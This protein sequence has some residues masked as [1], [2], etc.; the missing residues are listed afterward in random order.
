MMHL[1]IYITKHSLSVVS[2]ESRQD[3]YIEMTAMDANE[4]VTRVAPLKDVST[5]H[6]M[7]NNLFLQ[8]FQEF[9]RLS[10][11]NKNICLKQG[12]V[13]ARTADHFGVD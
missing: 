3:N 8:C 10:S 4:I 9:V 12:P 6:G 5:N 11:T 2:P 1:T 7:K 13:H